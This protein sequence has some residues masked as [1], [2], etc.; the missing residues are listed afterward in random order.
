M[1]RTSVPEVTLHHR[2]VPDHAYRPEHVHAARERAKRRAGDRFDDG[3]PSARM[4][5]TLSLLF[6]PICGIVI[7]LLARVI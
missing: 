7:Y 1:R 5:F 4:A 2:L 3:Y 6:W